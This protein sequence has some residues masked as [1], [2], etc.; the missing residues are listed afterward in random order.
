MGFESQTNATERGRLTENIIAKIEA[1]TIWKGIGIQAQKSPMA[2]APAALRRLICHKLG[3]LSA[4]PKC[5]KCG[6]FFNVVEWI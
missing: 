5:F 3:L 4:W 1:N 6:W 2:T